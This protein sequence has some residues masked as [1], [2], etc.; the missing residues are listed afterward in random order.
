MANVKHS[1]SVGNFKMARS[2]ALGNCSVHIPIRQKA[3]GWRHLIIGGSDDH[4]CNVPL[5]AI[6]RACPF[7][8][9]WCLTKYVRIMQ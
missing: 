4:L 5:D 6:T 2:P 1:N 3:H 8:V 9:I 7:V